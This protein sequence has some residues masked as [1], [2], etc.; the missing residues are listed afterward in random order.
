LNYH[1]HNCSYVDGNER[2]TYIEHNRILAPRIEYAT[3]D[4]RQA[5]LRRVSGPKSDEIIE[6]GETA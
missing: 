5:V 3:A 2:I 1:Q 4:S 6:D